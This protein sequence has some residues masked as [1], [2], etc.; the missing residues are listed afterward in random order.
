MGN[1]IIPNFLGF[2]FPVIKRPVFSTIV[3]TSTAGQET[4]IPEYPVPRLQ[5]TIPVNHLRMSTND[6]QK[7]WGLYVA[8]LGPWESLLYWDPTDNYTAAASPFG[9]GAGNNLVATGDGTTTSFQL[10]R[11]LGSSVSPLYDINGVTVS[12][13]GVQAP[14]STAVVVYLN[15]VNSP[16]GWTVSATGLLTFASAPGSGVTVSVDFAYFWRVRFMDDGLDFEQFMASIY[17]LGK[18]VLI[19]VSS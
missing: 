18:L 6:F 11:I 2:G 17:K 12:G 1:V 10:T 9:V 13:S 7:L 3:L 16:S 14:P 4:R 15:G 8:G 19:Q 5:F